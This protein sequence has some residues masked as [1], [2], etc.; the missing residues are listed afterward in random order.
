M[1][2]S[3]YSHLAPL[4]RRAEGK[5]VV[6]LEGF[7]AQ[8]AWRRLALRSAQKRGSEYSG[9]LPGTLSTHMGCFECSYNADLF[10]IPSSSLVR[11]RAGP[12]FP[13]SVPL[14]PT[15]TIFRYRYVFFR[16]QRPQPQLGSSRE[17]DDRA[18]LSRIPD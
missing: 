6:G 15:P 9:P 4:G 13:K 1:G 8:E 17:P 3:G 7:H 10:H 5:A 2:N 18:P 12:L 14:F 16:S 11:D